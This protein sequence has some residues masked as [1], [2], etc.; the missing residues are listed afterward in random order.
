MNTVSQAFF[1]WLLRSSWQAAVLTVLVVLVQYSL[2]KRLDGRWRHLLWFLV[3]TRLVMPWSPPSPASLF[4]YVHFERPSE[5]RPSNLPQSVAMAAPENPMPETPVLGQPSPATP[6]ASATR[7]PS[8]AR[9]PHLKK[10]AWPILL[11]VA[12]AIGISVFA[13]RLIIQNVLFRRRLHLATRTTDRQMIQLFDDCKSSMRITRAVEL[14]QTE[15]VQTPALYGFWR[16][17]LLMPRHMVG[18]FNQAELRYIFLH[19]LGH[20]RR[21]DM[22]AQWLMT[23]LQTV[24]WFNPVLWLGFRRMAAD[25][26]LACD[27]LALSVMGEGEGAAYGHTIVKLLEYCGEPSPL[28]GLVGILEDKNQI[29]RRVSMIAGFKRHSRWSIVGAAAVVVLG[30]ATLTGAQSEESLST[31]EPVLTRTNF[32]AATSSEI[33]QKVAT[34]A[35]DWENLPGVFDDVAIY[36]RQ[37]KELVD[38]GKPAVPALCTAL[39]HTDHDAS[40]RLLGFT[41]RAIGDPRAVPALIRA[42]P[43][44]LL[45]PGSDC[46]VVVGDPDL[47]TFMQSND[48]D[49]VQPLR[50]NSSFAMD[51]PVREIC[52]ALAKITVAHVDEGEIAFVFLNGGEQ[53]RAAEREAYHA[54]ASR[55]ADWWRTNHLQFVTDSEMGE[56]SLPALPAVDRGPTPTRFLTG[57]NI[58]VSEGVGGM[59]LAPVETGQNCC[60]SLSLNCSVGLPPQL[61]TTNGTAPLENISAWAAKARIDLFGVRYLDR[62]SGK[63]YYSLRGVGLQ[64][65]EI[66]NDR[67][68]TIEKDLQRGALPALDTPACDLLM[69]YKAES[70]RYVPERKATFLFITRDGYQG[71]MR[72]TGQITRKMSARDLGVPYIPPDEG[73]PNQSL[74]PG[75]FFGV[76]LDYKFFYEETARMKAEKEASE[77]AASSRFQ[78]WQNNRLATLLEKYPQMHGT[79]FSPDGHVVSNAMILIGVSG[80]SAVLSNGHFLSK[81]STVYATRADGQFT[82]PLLPRTQEAY[83]AHEKGFCQLNLNEAKSPLAIKLVPWGR[84]EG[85]VTVEGKLAPHQKIELM[86]DPRQW[87]HPE[88]Y[89]NLTYEAESDD[90]GRFVFNRVPP[91]EVE[92]CRMVDNAFYEEQVVDVVAGDTTVCQHGFNGRVVRGHLATTDA[93]EIQNW[94]KNVHLSFM[95]KTFSPEPPADE[96]PTSWLTSYWKT[97]EGKKAFRASYHFSS[98][99]ETNGD[100]R[101]EDVPPGTYQLQADLREGGGGQPWFFGNILGQ[102]KKDI[103]IP[104]GH[105][106]ETNGPLDLGNLVL[107]LK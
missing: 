72:V 65:W 76:K 86:N 77:H 45:P 21:H 2:G 81:E 96:D 75:P 28:P 27:E 56:V 60:L 10:P 50:E 61:S 5:G 22:A 95:S 48:L 32:S 59:I 35:Q 67:W 105:G 16:L 43:K 85:T 24:H 9:E 3:V 52:G 23:G 55:W 90:Q 11:A 92:V 4:N 47:L 89:V 53:Q 87:L 69:H 31:N 44:T 30:L 40:L 34:V 97:V 99:V 82:I 73:D 20:V 57:T 37:V 98:T 103:V 17:Q 8:F 78:A 49:A 102:L 70:A 88:T 42:I 79:V 51:R 12:W 54:A 18:R 19:E 62:Q 15:L 74:D 84:I 71:I 107:E 93:T 66:P 25:R 46:G 39:D 29:F 13:A 104:E 36:S 38:I 94:K 80:E 91:G 68:F 1:E 41:L 7:P 101:I 33:D 6:A 83:V 100:F 64:A 14:V 63:S 58:K 106:N 26:E